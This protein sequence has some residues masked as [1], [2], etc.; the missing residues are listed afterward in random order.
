[1]SQIADTMYEFFTN[2]KTEGAYLLLFVLSLVILYRVDKD[3]N[4]FHIVY[5]VLLALLVICN[6]LTVWLLSMAFPAIRNYEQLV[7]LIPIFLYVPYG[8]TE[9]VCSIRSVRTSKIVAVL[10]FLYVALCGNFFGLFPGNTRTEYNLYDEDKVRLVQYIESNTKRLA[11]VD[12][13]I[14]PFVTAYGDTVPLVYG[15]DIMLFNTDLGIMDT[16]DETEVELHN[17]MWEP[18]KHID[19]I[20]RLAK[21]KGCDIMVVKNYE[22]AVSYVDIYRE[23]LKTDDYIVYRS[24]G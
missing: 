10:L 23:V 21:S 19:E 4:R 16:Y 9:L 24:I 5:S 6:P 22:G 7:V 3:R 15:Y 12:D 17:M 20:A 11:L 14:L 1:M 18:M 8:I 13:G 2:S